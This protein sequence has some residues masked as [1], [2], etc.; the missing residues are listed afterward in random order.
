MYCVPDFPPEKVDFE[1]SQQTKTKARKNYLICKE[2]MT[3]FDYKGN[4]K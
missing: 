2:L 3:N 1:K 4:W